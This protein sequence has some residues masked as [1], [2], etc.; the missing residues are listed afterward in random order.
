MSKAFQ[1]HK[2]Q[3][4]MHFILFQASTGLGGTF[5]KSKNTFILFSLLHFIPLHHQA[6]QLRIFVQL[7]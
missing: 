2:I 5:A 3:F 6:Q 1:L 7:I 4:Q